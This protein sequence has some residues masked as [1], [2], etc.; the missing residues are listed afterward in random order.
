MRPI[1]IPDGWADRN[2]EPGQLVGTKVVAPPG[3]DL[4]NPDIGAIEGMVRHSP[5]LGGEVITFL[6]KPE[7]DDVGMLAAGGY[8]ALTFN[9]PI[10]VHAMQV[11]GD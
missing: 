5:E 7:G 11:V 1:P 2:L 4:T 8:I 9:G 6:W 3:G 10:A